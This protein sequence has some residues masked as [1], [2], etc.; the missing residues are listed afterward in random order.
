VSQKSPIL[1][2]GTSRQLSS[3]VSRTKMASLRHTPE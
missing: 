3:F 2:L 1:A